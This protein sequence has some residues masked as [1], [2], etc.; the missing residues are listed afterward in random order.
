MMM[1]MMMMIAMMVQM[2][3]TAFLAKVKEM[4]VVQ[5]NYCR[6]HNSMSVPDSLVPPLRTHLQ[7]MS[8]IRTVVN[9]A[10]VCWNAFD[11]LSQSCSLLCYYATVN[12]VESEVTS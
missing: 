12:M 9:G 10:M 1:M 6:Y 4:N 5:H 11:S 8:T 7:A 2:T 3:A